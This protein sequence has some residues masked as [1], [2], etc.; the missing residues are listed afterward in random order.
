MRNPGLYPSAADYKHLFY[1]LHQ[2]LN[3]SEARKVIASVVVA[4]N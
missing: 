3:P 4:I 2:Y 1:T